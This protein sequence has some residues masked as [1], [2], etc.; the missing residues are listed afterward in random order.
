MLPRRILA[1]EPIPQKAGPQPL[2][3][4]TRDETGLRRTTVWTF[5]TREYPA[6]ALSTP[7]SRKGE[8]AKRFRSR[9]GR[10]GT[11]EEAGAEHSGRRMQAACGAPVGS[12]R[13]ID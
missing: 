1:Q 9:P 11:L 13:R 5:I 2:G 12:A 4:E 6:S 8:G 10:T 3:P 7:S